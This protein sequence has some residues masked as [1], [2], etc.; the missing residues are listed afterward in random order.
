MRVMLKQE[1][2]ISKR[3]SYKFDFVQVDEVQDTHLSE[4]RHR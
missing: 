4:Y 1:Q 3:W 2:E